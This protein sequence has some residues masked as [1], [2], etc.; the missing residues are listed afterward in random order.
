MTKKASAP[1]LTPFSCAYST[2]TTA[3]YSPLSPT[4]LLA[5]T[6]TFFLSGDLI[7]SLPFSFPSM[8]ASNLTFGAGEAAPPLEPAEDMVDDIEASWAASY[9]DCFVAELAP[10][11]DWTQR[12]TR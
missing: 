8:L 3:L 7:S 9:S 6:L 4:D 5:L 12:D 10:R 11:G 2:H 1:H